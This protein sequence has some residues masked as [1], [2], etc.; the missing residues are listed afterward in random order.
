MSWETLP[1]QTPSLD[2]KM[3][4][5][6]RTVSFIDV[7]ISTCSHYLLP[8]HSLIMVFYFLLSPPF[9]PKDIFSRLLALTSTTSL[10]ISATFSLFLPLF[11]RHC[12]LGSLVR[13]Q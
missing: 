9:T 3:G 10:H 7:P 2:M 11:T 8:V 6:H 4:T 12:L 13:L 5:G 1:K